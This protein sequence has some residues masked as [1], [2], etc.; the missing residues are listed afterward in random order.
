MLEEIIIKSI[1]SLIVLLVSLYVMELILK[2]FINK[3]EN[4]NTKRVPKTNYSPP[5]RGVVTAND[6]TF[7]PPEQVTRDINKGKLDE[8]EKC[9]NSYILPILDRD[10]LVGYICNECNYHKYFKEDEEGD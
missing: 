1:L 6:P 5:E 8:C 3:H 2:Y 7:D 10:K 9:G 4:N